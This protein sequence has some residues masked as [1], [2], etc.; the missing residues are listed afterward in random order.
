MD[1]PAGLD[2]LLSLL[3]PH[4]WP[5]ALCSTRLLPVTLMC[6]LLGGA[7]APMMVR[8]TLALMLSLF[9]HIGGGVSVPD[10]VLHSGWLLA[11]IFARQL[12]LGL[13]VGFLASVPFDAARIGG[14]LLDTFRSANAEVQLPEVGQKDAA[15]AGLLHQLLCATLFAAGGYKLGLDAVL[16]GFAL[17]PLSSDGVNMQA[18]FEQVASGALTSTAVGL[19]IGAPAAATSLVVDV[20]LGLVARAAP[21]LRLQET[22]TPAKLGLGAAAILLSLGTIG[23]RLLELASVSF[24]GMNHLASLAP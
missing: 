16:R 15:T 21:Q 18:V 12:C 17:M 6:P 13:A 7:Q 9:V 20:G 5:V 10:A 19:A 23:D 14:R 2:H 8:L 4:F 1:L 24:A 3:S 22:A 11:P